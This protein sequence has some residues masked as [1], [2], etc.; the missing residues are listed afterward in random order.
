M[1]FVH[2]AIAYKQYPQVGLPYK[3]DGGCS[4]EILKRTSKRYQGPVSWAWLEFFSPLKGTNSKTTHLTDSNLFRLNTLKGTVR[5]CTKTAFLTP[6]RY[7]EPP[8]VL[9]K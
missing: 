7:D 5:R 4:S 6:E 1:D 2:F 3:K 9:F 8:P